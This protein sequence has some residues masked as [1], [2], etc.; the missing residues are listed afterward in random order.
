MLLS[1][2]STGALAANAGPEITQQPES[3]TVTA[4]AD[5]RA[6]FTIQTAGDPAP[7]CQWQVKNGETWTD[8]PAAVK[9]TYTVPNP[10]VAMD[11]RQYRCQVTSGETT[12]YSNVVTLTVK[13]GPEP[14]PP[15]LKPI[16]I[17]DITMRLPVTGE[18]PYF[19]IPENNQ[20]SAFLSWFPNASPT[21]GEGLIFTATIHL[22]PKQGY[23]LQGLPED[24]FRVKGASSVTY[25]DGKIDVVFPR[26]S[27]VNLLNVEVVNQTGHG[28]VT[29]SPSACVEGDTVTLTVT[30]DERHVLTSLEIFNHSEIPLTDRGNGVYTFVMPWCSVNVHASFRHATLPP[31]YF[32]D[33]YADWAYE[34]ILYL[35][36]AGIMSGTS[37]DTFSPY[38]PMSRSM[39][40]A[41]LYRI[42][43]EPALESNAMEN[44]FGDVKPG[45]W[46]S[47]AVYWARQEGIITG[48]SAAR[49][50]PSSSITREQ[51]AA[52]LWRNAGS[53]ET[54]NRP[55]PFRDA[56]SI[57]GYALPA[58]RWA[59]EQGI[60]KGN[61]DGTL[62]PKDTANRQQVATILWRY[63]GSPLTLPD[64]STPEP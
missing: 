37:S 33:D 49:F 62:H 30:P 35:H 32:Q 11:G 43:G 12:V 56:G 31:V 17:R 1:L 46:Y 44:P 18:R 42:A 4:G 51:I 60:L 27:G 2:L 3:C 39:L 57:A 26:T 38:A 8:I 53:P 61:E 29:V 40:A 5:N 64:V 9:P 28:S 13:E 14:E 54:E 25:K 20:Y 50:G 22:Q 41:V 63:L 45:T 10:V 7:A 34:A 58:V 36:G 21:F 23:T 6:K 19:I 15:Q 55:L 16:T 48:F 52:L 59:V 24:F 47:D